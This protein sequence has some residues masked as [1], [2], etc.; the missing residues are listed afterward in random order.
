PKLNRQITTLRANLV[1]AHTAVPVR[2]VSDGATDV[3]IQKFG[4]LGAVTEQTLSLYPGRYTA[5]G[6]RSGYRDTRVEFT[7]VAG[8]AVPTIT[9]KCQEVLSFRR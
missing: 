8:A 9:V 6:K 3:T 5:L 1:A 2:V 7:V 4:R